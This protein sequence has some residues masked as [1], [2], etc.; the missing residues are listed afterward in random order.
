MD[1]LINKVKKDL[2]KGQKD[3]KVL[4]KADKKFDRKVEKCNMKMKKKKK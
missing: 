4:K 3:V 2:S 1:N